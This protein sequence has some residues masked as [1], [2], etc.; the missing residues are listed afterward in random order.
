[1]PDLIFN[2]F[3]FIF[4]SY[5]FIRFKTDDAIGKHF[6]LRRVF[7]VLDNVILVAGLAVIFLWFVFFHLN[8]L[9]FAIETII[10]IVGFL[11]AFFIG[12]NPAELAHGL[13]TRIH[14]IKTG[15]HEGFWS[16]YDSNRRKRRAAIALLVALNAAVAAGGLFLFYHLSLRFDPASSILSPF[17]A[18]L[19]L[20]SLF[21]F[22]FI[23]EY[24]GLNRK[25]QPRDHKRRQELENISENMAIASGI[26]ALATRIADLGVPDAFSIWNAKER[27]YEIIVSSILLNTLDKSELEAVIAHQYSCVGSG[28]IMDFR[29]IGLLLSFLKAS[30]GGFLVLAVSAYHPFLFFVW[31]LIA[32]GLA[33]ETSRSANPYAVNEN[34]KIYAIFVFLMPT[35]SIINFCGCLIYYYLGFT[36]S[37]SADLHAILLTRFPKGLYSAI[38]KT[39]KRGRELGTS[40]FADLGHVYF[41]GANTYNHVPAVQPSAAFRKAMIVRIDHSLEGF[42]AVNLPSAIACPL[43]RKAMVEMAADSHYYK[44]NVAIDRCPACGG[45]WFDKAELHYIAD[46]TIL[47]NPVAGIEREKLIGKLAC[48]RCGIT[49]L[50]DESVNIPCH[51]DIW[52]C[53]TCHGSFLTENDVYEYGAVKNFG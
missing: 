52:K 35:F 16:L 3:I 18:I 2:I 4:L 36:E 22:I 41:S 34:S 39:E 14:P 45:I 27:K 43:C 37:V 17:P 7:G 26:P 46:L 48:P 19:L 51:I 53:P 32:F 20:A 21:A 8:D 42:R 13:I 33:F 11:A 24:Y 40:I 25:Y 28:Q 23:V 31:F 5:F 44:G 29:S 38:V 30:A 50:C 15:E 1:M 47:A 6:A 49:L 10:I 9:V 12:M